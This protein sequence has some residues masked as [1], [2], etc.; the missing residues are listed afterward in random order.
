MASDILDDL[1]DIVLP[2]LTPYEFALYVYLLRKSLAVG[3]S[4][5]IRVGKRTIAAD[6]GR[7]SRGS[8]GPYGHIGKLLKSLADKG[9]LWIGDTTRQ[10]TLYVVTHP[11]RIKARTDTLES[12]V[13]KADW[14]RDP[15]L[16]RELFER[17]NL[18]C[19]Y[20]G[21]RVSADNATL[22]HIIPSSQ[23]GADSSDNLTTCCLMCNSVKSGRSYKEAAPDILESVRSRRASDI[24]SS[25]DR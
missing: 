19:R 18:I 3:I 17:D 16:R 2:D 25:N 12:A 6:C 10:G 13:A 24:G 20:C 23:G 4:G 1:V 22:D 14:F 11:S 5:Q 7:G 8:N 21:D 9:Y 15:L